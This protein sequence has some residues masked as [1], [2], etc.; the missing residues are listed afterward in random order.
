[1]VTVRSRITP[2]VSG[3]ELDL[4]QFGMHNKKVLLCHYTHEPKIATQW[5][6]LHAH[7]RQSPNHQRIANQSVP[8]FV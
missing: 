4:G 8:A 3:L 6:H 5:T 2:I 1:M 7:C